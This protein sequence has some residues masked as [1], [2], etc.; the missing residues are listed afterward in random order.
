MRVNRA[1][2]KLRIFFTKRGV[3]LTTAII[4]VTISAN[5][6]HAAPVGLAMTVTAAAVKGSVTA[7]STMTLT[8]GTIKLMAW[9]K[10]KTMAVVGVAAI[11]AAGTTTIAIKE[12]AKKH[13]TSWKSIKNPELATQLKSFVAEKATQAQGGGNAMP[14]VFS[15]FFAPAQRG[16]WPAVSNVFLEISEITLSNMNIPDGRTTACVEWCGKP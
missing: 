15:P 7:A 3:S 11:L 13:S 4:A 5:S 14:P 9:A 6:V 8:K 10:M 2:E 1:L 12:V 16:D